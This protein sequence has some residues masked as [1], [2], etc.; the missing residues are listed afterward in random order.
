VNETS[1]ASAE[2]APWS[3]GRV[4]TWAT[5]DFRAR[6]FDS[7]RLDA[8]LLLADALGLDRV[9]LF[10]EHERALT[11]DELARYRAAIQ[12]RRKGE[13]IAYIRGVREFFG[14]P[15]QVDSRVLVPRPDTE[16][17]VE[18][19]LR[20]TDQHDLFGT[21]LDVCTGSG[22]VALAFAS[23]RRTWRV[24]ASDVSEDALVVARDNALRLGINNVA[25]KH[26]DLFAALD[27]RLKFTL[28]TANPPYIPEAEIPS[29]QVD[30]RDFEPHLALSGGPDGLDVVRRLILDARSRLTPG[31][32]LALELHYD[33]AERVRD[34]LSAAGY[35][36]IETNQDYGG[37]QRVVSAAAPG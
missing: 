26:S 10:L 16:I 12:R 36:A 20:R 31:A 27:P 34:L 24:W 25:F 2:E 3:V 30:V 33:Q 13:P 14:L 18:T 23:R 29:L 22:C 11:S 35:N 15:I 21:A 28:I 6:G 19:A 8:E 5:Q 17:L 7:P 32:C 37:H 1:V 9:R 4:L